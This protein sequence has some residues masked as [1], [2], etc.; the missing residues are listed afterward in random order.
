MMRWEK[1]V[2]LL[3]SMTAASFWAGSPTSTASLGAGVE[4]A[5]HDVRPVDEVLQRAG[6]EPEAALGDGGDQLGA[7]L[8]AGI[9]ELFVAVPAPEV[10]LVLGSQ[11][12]AVVVV[13]PPGQPLVVG[14][15]E[16]HDGVL[17]PLEEVVGKGL[18]GLVGHAE[19]P[20]TGPG[21]DP[22]GVEAHED[23][24]RA[25]AVEA[26]VMIEDVTVH[27]FSI[28]RDPIRSSR[29]RVRQAGPRR[30]APLPNGIVPGW[31]MQA[32]STRV[33]PSKQALFPGPAPSA[34]PVMSRESRSRL[35]VVVPWLP[36]RG[37]P[38]GGPPRRPATRPK[39]MGPWSG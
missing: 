12:G 31:E 13:E 39:E 29:S 1:E 24:G 36:G 10:G 27:A 2:S 9:E 15:L 4:G 3:A 17:V 7:G 30:P 35:R 14:V 33:I 16:V 8:E 32:S 25:G 23:G 26:V 34:P 18:V 20:E 11:E 19:Q 21:V 37:G 5:V 6:V 38:A 28:R 22:G